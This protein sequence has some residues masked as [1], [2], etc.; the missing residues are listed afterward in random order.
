MRIKMKVGLSGSLNGVPYPPPGV[1]WEV[2]DEAGAKLCE[3]GMAVPVDVL[4]RV[5]TAVAPDAETRR[6]GLTTT[7][8]RAVARQAEETS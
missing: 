6:G 3:K 8:A 4:G 7:K 1:E 2:A 5:E